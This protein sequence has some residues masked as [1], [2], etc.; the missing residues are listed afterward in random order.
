VTGTLAISSAT[1][2]IIEILFAALVFR[3]ANSIRKELG[4]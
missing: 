4:K 2:S 1:G 3:A